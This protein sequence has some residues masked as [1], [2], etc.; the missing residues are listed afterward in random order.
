MDPASAPSLNRLLRVECPSCH[1]SQAVETITRHGR[2]NYFCPTCEHSWDT[3]AVSPDDPKTYLD[4][5]SV[6]AAVSLAAI[7][8]LRRDRHSSELVIRRSAESRAVLGSRFLSYLTD[9][10]QM[11]RHLNVSAA[12]AQHVSLFEVVIPGCSSAADVAVALAAHIK[13]AR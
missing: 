5:P 2:T 4:L 10:E 6:D 8:F 1:H 12:I 13:G 3:P 11:V 7:Y 9:V